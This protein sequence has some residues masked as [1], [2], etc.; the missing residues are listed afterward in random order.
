VVVANF[1]DADHLRIEAI[2]PTSA[3]RRPSRLRTGAEVVTLALAPTEGVTPQL[4]NVQFSYFSGM[5]AWRPIVV[6]IALLA[7]GNLAGFILLSRDVS[8]FLRRRLAVRRGG[9]PEFARAAGA[10]LPR[11]LADRITPGSTTEAE[12]VGLCG[13]PDEEHHRRG[14][15][16]RR[17]LVYRGVRRL[18]SRRLALGPLATVRHWEDEYHD[19]EVELDGD[20][21]TAVQSRVR[22]QRVTG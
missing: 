22:R 11:A 3:T 16:A 8:Q 12:V 1:A 18:P 6:S 20:R 21:V 15:T 5:I 10:A 14:A 13:R 4:L 17:T 7:L 2:A 19:L 9:E